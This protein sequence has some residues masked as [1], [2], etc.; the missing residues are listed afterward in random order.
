MVQ[1]E[2]PGAPKCSLLV[3]A[4]SV[5][6]A[7]D[8]L[9]AAVER[10]AAAGAR[11]LLAK[12]DQP[13]RVVTWRDLQDQAAR[14]AQH[15]L[16]LGLEQGGRV[17]LMLP[18][19]EDW[20]ASFFGTLLAGGVPVPVGPTFSFGGIDKYVSTVQ[21]IARDAGA[22]FFIGSQ[23]AEA[24]WPALTENNPTL[25]HFLRPES[26]RTGLG[27][28]TLRVPSPSAGDL[29]VL[30]YTSGT[31]SLPKGVML[32]HHSLLANAHMI[33]KRVGMTPSDVGVSWLP[34][35]H[36]MGLVGALMTSL[37]WHYSLLLTPVES[38]LMHPRRWLQSISSLRATLTVA[39]NFAYQ[40]AV[41]RISDRH[42]D[43]LD[44]SSWRCA[45]NGS[46]MVRSSTLNAFGARFGKNGF[47]R[48]AFLPV[49]GMAENTLAATF[50][51]REASWVATTLKRD[52]LE[53]RR[54]EPAPP[55]DGAVEIVAVGT[56]LAGTRV[57]IQGDDG[58]DVPLGVLGE[59]AVRSPSLMD[60]YFRNDTATQAALRN[61]WL[62]T[63]DLGFIADG[64]LYVTG[65]AKEIIIKRGRNYYPDD[66]ESAAME[67]S[68]NG[69]VRAA[70]AFGCPDEA[71]GTESVVLVLETKRIDEQ[72]RL[73]LDKAVNGALIA[74]FG[75][76][77]DVVVFVPQRT[78]PR[79]T[80]G[81]V[82]RTALRAQYLS[83]QLVR[84]ST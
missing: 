61:G 51:P 70:A 81:K 16:Q 83:G 60:G 45:F 50:P 71:T 62:R 24:H 46:E 82:R 72:E 53:R 4:E 52:A 80:S 33:G 75:I 54:V 41:D 43:G 64:Q 37:Y 49:Y 15:L 14:V 30:Q 31:T 9:P 66:L 2:T 12:G 35:F 32:S 76:R 44:L 58:R 36:D 40:T 84:A 56:P 69:S 26:L 63:G 34:L 17:V 42:A 73:D 77:A 55:G 78:I 65:R 6:T 19:G 79:T 1:V 13:P 21:H 11:L 5:A 68:D 39:P 48:S 27:T 10:A 28:R 59:I 23:H 8:T 20:L 29:A 22:R 67:A 7:V 25:Q 47:C 57:A 3:N 38:F 74:A 18:T